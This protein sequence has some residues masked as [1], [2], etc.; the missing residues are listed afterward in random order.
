MNDE[1]SIRA[2]YDDWIRATVEG[3]LSLA[4]GLVA[5]DAVFLVPGAGEMDGRAY[6]EA[7]TG[8]DPTREY[9]LDSR[10]REIR[11]LGDHAVLWTEFSLKSR[12]KDTGKV[13]A[14]AGHTLSLLVRDGASW[15]VVRDANTMAAV[16]AQ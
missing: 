5:E 15:R 8:D 6:A 9:E 3:D 2:W 16:A 7:A 1:G 11:V 14:S 12:R 4:L 13:S 10:I